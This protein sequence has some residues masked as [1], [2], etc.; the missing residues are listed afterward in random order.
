MAKSI[1]TGMAPEKDDD[2][3]ISYLAGSGERVK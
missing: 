3:T 1:K 2:K